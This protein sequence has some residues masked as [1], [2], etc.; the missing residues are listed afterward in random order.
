MQ[1]IA[2]DSRTTFKLHSIMH[3]NSGHGG[4]R[5]GA[6]RS[7]G[8]GR[9][10]EPTRVVRVPESCVPAVQQMLGQVVALR[11]YPKATGELEVMRPVSN[12]VAMARPLFSCA[13]PAGFPSP[14]DDYIEG[15]LDLNKYFVEHPA[16]TFYVRVTGESMTGVGIFPDDILV[17]DR[18]LEAQHGK[19]VIAVV[20][21]ELTV[22][23]LY[24]RGGIIELRPENPTFPA[25]QCKDDMELVI[26]GVVTGVMRKC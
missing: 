23:R 20:N 13:V 21:R 7:R 26:W 12:P 2:L 6:G 15:Q 9:Y 24:R 5:N 25:I 1:V 10:G 17:V 11:R 14:A 18:S 3:S 16:A 22:K 19:I 4:K 8:T